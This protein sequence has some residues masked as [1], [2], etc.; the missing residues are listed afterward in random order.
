VRGP[1]NTFI[2]GNNEIGLALAMTVP[3]MYYLYRQSKSRLI[4]SGL[5]AGMVLTAIAAIGTQSRGALVGMAAMSTMLWLR[6]KQKLMLLVIGGVAAFAIVHIMPEEWYARMRTI[7]HHEG[8]PAVE[9]RFAAWREAYEVA[10]T[11]F[12]GGGFEVLRGTDAHSIYFEVLGEHGYVGLSLFLLLGLLT[13]FSASRIRR[14]A[15][16]HKETLWLA[17]L[18]RMVQV[19]M[20]AYATA[21]SFLG[22]AYF[23]YFYN[24]VLVV[25][26][27]G[28]VL[29]KELAALTSPTGK[30]TAGAMAVGGPVGVGGSRVRAT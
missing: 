25:V 30:E 8:D 10:N 7:Q 9:G 1:A 19:S 6:G 20:V 2:D 12:M 22:M 11:Y 24:L 16:R 28:V 21:G 29:E 26:M 13:W 3:L 23:D 4:R 17:D 18:S 27:S 14:H 5:V 15:Q